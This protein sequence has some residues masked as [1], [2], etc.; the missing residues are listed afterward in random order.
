M[1]GATALVSLALA[2][3]GDSTPASHTAS[4]PARSPATTASAPTHFPAAGS[5][6]AVAGDLRATIDGENHTP[7]VNQ[8]WRYS[9]EVTNSSGGAVSGNV[10]IEFV[11]AGQVV[12]YDKPPTHPITNGLWQSTLRFPGSAVGFP[13]TLRAVAH[14]GA[15]SITLNWPITVRQA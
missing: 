13:L 11:L 7:T 15:G 1:L 5:K 4:Q 3:C 2:G 6:S 12:A 9:L 14:T 8:P 10:A